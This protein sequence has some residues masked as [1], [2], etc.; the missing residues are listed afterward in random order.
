MV[1]DY[2]KTEKELYLPKTTPS[3]IDVPR[4]TFITVDGKVI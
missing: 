2:K 1:I 4:M 3:L